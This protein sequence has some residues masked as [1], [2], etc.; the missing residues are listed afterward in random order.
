MCKRCSAKNRGERCV[1]VGSHGSNT[2]PCI[3]ILYDRLQLGLDFFS[4]AARASEHD[5]RVANYDIRD[6]V[7]FLAR[8]PVPSRKFDEVFLKSH[9]RTA[10]CLHGLE[11]S[12]GLKRG[13]GSSPKAIPR[14]RDTSG[15]PFPR[16]VFLLVIKE[17]QTDQTLSPVAIRLC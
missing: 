7:A 16:M 11:R 4:A 15:T 9:T 10:L 3:Q 6:D 17:P 5:R 8:D 12:R 13:T 1:R 2:A 14:V